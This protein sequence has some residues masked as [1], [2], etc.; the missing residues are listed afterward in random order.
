MSRLKKSL[1]FLLC[2]PPLVLFSIVLYRSQTL[3]NFGWLKSYLNN[4][5]SFWY[6]Y[7]QTIFWLSLVLTISTIILM[8][9]I[10]FYPR[11]YSEV[12][13]SE[14]NGR[15]AIKK[16]A[17]E[18]HVK[19]AV[20]SSSYMASPKV[21]VKLT[22]KKCE[23]TVKGDII[24]GVD[25]VNRTNA[26]QKEIINGLNAYLGLNHDI[27]LNVKVL[28]TEAEQHKEKQAEVVESQPVQSRVK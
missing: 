9:A 8:I 27:Y 25:V 22:K 10:L 5:S 26:L 11:D 24:N 6:Y 18:N 14:A 23:V 15:L 7:N 12:M 2:I 13:L 28:N 3:V 4:L 16:S 19:S 1:L 17:I 21:N 20:E